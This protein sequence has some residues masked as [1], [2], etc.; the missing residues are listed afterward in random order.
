V[1]RAVRSF[2]LQA[3]LRLLKWQEIAAV[4]PSPLGDFLAEKYGIRASP[5]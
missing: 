1:I 4:L 5:R 2:E 3:R